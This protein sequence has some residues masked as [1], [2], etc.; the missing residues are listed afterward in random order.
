M[1]LHFFSN[2][3]FFVFKNLQQST[4]S[5]ICK[6]SSNIYVFFI[7]FNSFSLI[8]DLSH[9]NFFIFFSLFTE[10]LIAR[11]SIQGELG[12]GDNWT[13]YSSRQATKEID[14]EYRV[15]C[16]STYYGAGCETVC[17]ER[18]DNFGHYACSASGQRMCF[19]GWQ[20]DYCTKRKSVLLFNSFL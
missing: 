13:Q 6:T 4:L 18:D 15:K 19:S 9:N 3:Y 7:S 10:S 16:E 8:D 20:G 12:I 5:L 14:F 17:R 11:F 2:V 1:L